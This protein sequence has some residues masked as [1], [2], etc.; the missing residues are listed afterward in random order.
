VELVLECVFH[1]DLSAPLDTGHG[2]AGSRLVIPVTGGWVKG[3]RLNGTVVGPGGDWALL[4]GDGFARLDVRGQVETD[5][6]AVIYVSYGGLLELNEA[7]MGGLAGGS[8]AYDDHYFRITP[9]FETGDDRYRWL[10]T[11]LFVGRGRLV[12]DAVE[13]EIH[14]LT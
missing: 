10:N 2:P 3:A 5:D 8:T 1:A 14:R 7:A 4:G 9:R 6:G 12:P 13:Y 11:A